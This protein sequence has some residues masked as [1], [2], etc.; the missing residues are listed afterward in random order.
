MTRKR[1]YDNATRASTIS[2]PST[3]APRNMFEDEVQQEE[4]EEERQLVG[5][6]ARYFNSLFLS[7]DL[8]DLRLEAREELKTQCYAGKRA[9][10]RWRQQQLSRKTVSILLPDAAGALYVRARGRRRAPH[11]PAHRRP[12]A[13]ASACRLPLLPASLHISLILVAF[14][15][16][17]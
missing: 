16:L 1:F 8:T 9:E 12:P 10:R 6:T 11:P 5:M 2:F 17:R 14:I 13:R 4:R 15:L 3:P 7:S